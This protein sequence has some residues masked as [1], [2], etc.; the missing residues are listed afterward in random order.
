MMESR[1]L[2]RREW[3]IVAMDKVNS[4]NLKS[5][6]RG[7]DNPQ[8]VGMSRRERRNLARAYAAAG[9]KARD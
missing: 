9:W 5:A 2:E 3:F 6:Y 1:Q 7:T 4:A 8:M